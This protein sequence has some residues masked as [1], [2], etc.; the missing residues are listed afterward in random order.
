MSAVIEE[1]SLIRKTILVLLAVGYAG[2]AFPEDAALRGLAVGIPYT[3]A[4]SGHT[5]TK[6]AVFLLAAIPVYRTLPSALSALI[7]EASL[8]RKTILVLLAVGYAGDAFPEGAVLRSLAV[9]IPI[10]LAR[11]GQ[12]TT[13]FAVFLL[14]AIPAYRTLPSALSA[15]IEEASLIR[16]TI[17]VLLAVGYNAFPE[18]AALRGLAVGIPVTLARSGQTTTKLAVFDLAAVPV[19]RTL[20]CSGNAMPG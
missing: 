5:T 1:A 20:P 13:K 11:S 6:F 12:T 19:Q 7:E 10:T 9:G 8:I 4:R 3:L 18:G 14:A 2:D 15:L 17:L 16:K